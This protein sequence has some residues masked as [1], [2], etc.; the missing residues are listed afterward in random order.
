MQKACVFIRLAA[1]ALR[2]GALVILGFAEAPQSLINEYA[3]LI[4]IGAVA[5]ALFGMQTFPKTLANFYQKEDQEYIWQQ[6]GLYISQIIFILGFAG[7][8]LIMAED[9]A[10][11]LGLLIVAVAIAEGLSFEASRRL[12]IIDRQLMANIMLLVVS[13]CYFLWSLA[14]LSIPRLGSLEM[15]SGMLAATIP[16]S[17]A[18]LFV[19]DYDVVG[20]GKFR[21][22]VKNPLPL[23]KASLPYLL[24]QS[25][26]V[27]SLYFPRFYVNMENPD[28]MSDFTILFSISNVIVLAL[29]AGIIAPATPRAFGS[30]GQEV[31]AKA[32]KAIVI[33]GTLALALLVMLSPIWQCLLPF[34]GESGLIFP[35]IILGAMSIILC[36]SQLQQLQL[37]KSDK[38]VPLVISSF[39]GA[40]VVTLL[41]YFLVPKIPLIGATLSGL[42]GLIAVFL[43]RKLSVPKWVNE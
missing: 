4:S 13:G 2:F 29:T 40:I 42:S 36:L 34:S 3:F 1:T 41:T 35:F 43:Y 32:E 26:H 20:K 24:V 28:M 15:L 19:S 16:L 17:A 21:A 18:V 27:F 22:R 7:I 37:T 38:T 39:C 6:N 10:S 11:R 25:L 5:T 23:L 33:N 14:A 30:G 9:N 31:I 12:I 8:F